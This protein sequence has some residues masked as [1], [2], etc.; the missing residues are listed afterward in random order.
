MEKEISVTFLSLLHLL[1]N[2]SAV[3]AKMR[4]FQGNRT[5]SQQI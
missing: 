5:I 4:P 3:A 1:L 2:P